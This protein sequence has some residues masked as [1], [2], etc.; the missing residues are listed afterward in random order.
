MLMQSYRYNPQ[1]KTLPII[2]KNFFRFT[3]L[4]IEYFMIRIRTGKIQNSNSRIDST[5]E[6]VEPVPGGEEV[7]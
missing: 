1:K 2:N 4:F 3:N 7:L 6:G 5:G